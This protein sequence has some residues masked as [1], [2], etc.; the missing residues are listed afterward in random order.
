MESRTLLSYS[1]VRVTCVALLSAVGALLY[2]MD[3]G[4]IGP[5]IECASFKED[6]VHISSEAS[7]DGSTAGLLVAIFSIGALCTSFPGS[8]SYFLDVWGRRDS[9][10]LGGLLFAVGCVVQATATG[11][12]RFACG[13]FL[14]GCSVGLL[15]TVT[16]L[17]QGELAPPS[18][19]GS[20]TVLYQLMIGLG[21]LLATII[22]EFLV[23]TAEGWRAVLWLQLLPAIILSAGMCYL[24]RSPRWLIQRDRHEE[25]LRALLQVRE[26]KEAQE[27]VDQ[28]IESHRLDVH[29]GAPRWSEVFSGRAG[30]LLAIGVSL[31]LLQQACGLNAIGYFGPTIT[32][33]LHLINPNLFQSIINV[34]GLSATVFATFSADRHGRKILLV[35]GAAG[36]AASSAAIGTL[37][38]VFMVEV[39]GQHRLLPQVVAGW[40][41]MLAMLTF[42]ASFACSWG[43]IVLV[44]CSEIFPLRLRSRCIGVTTTANWIGNFC[45]AQLTP[46]MFDAIGFGT[47]LLFSAFSFVGLLLATW[48][49]ETKGVPL[50]HIDRVFDDKLGASTSSDDYRGVFSDG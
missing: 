36:M 29:A 6:I 35:G 19:R 43:P 39:G 38:V 31:Q 22:D 4:Y 20:L 7:I 33:R 49:P 42:V 14:S 28:I 34:V 12:R 10:V 45:I 40:S 48:L 47:F 25:A 50:E 26:E 18:M 30:A 8:S 5:I 32:S 27:E 1:R 41:V 2:G 9:I 15:S 46:V 16:P 24:P 17:Y 37:G 11:I 13:R 21:A 44:Y 23:D 3:L